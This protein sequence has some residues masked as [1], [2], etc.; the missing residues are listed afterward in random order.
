MRVKVM[1]QKWIYIKRYTFHGQNVACLK[2]QETHSSDRVEAISEGER[3]PK[4]GVVS[5][6][7]LNNSI[8]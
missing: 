5:F 2:R 4:Y 1:G 7:W 6:Y 8:G 3:S